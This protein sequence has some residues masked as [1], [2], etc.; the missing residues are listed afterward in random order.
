M[1]TTHEMFIVIEKVD[2]SII[3]Q[4]TCLFAI[5]QSKALTSCQATTDLYVSIDEFD[6]FE[7]VE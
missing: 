4:I 7:N 1:C 3:L 2:I 6:F 5:P